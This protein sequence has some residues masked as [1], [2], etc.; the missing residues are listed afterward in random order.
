RSVLDWS[1]TIAPGHQDWLAFHRALLALR[2]RAIAPLLAGEATPVA[3]WKNLGDTALEISWGF[4]A[5]VLRLLANLG[6]QPVAHDGPA[7]W[8]RRL[9]ALNLPTPTWSTLPPWSVVVYLAGARP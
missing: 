5:G 3:A 6:T 9:Y 8:G 4:P 2:A 7:D 1:R